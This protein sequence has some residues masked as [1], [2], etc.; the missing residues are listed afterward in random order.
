[1]SARS[2]STCWAPSTAG[3]AVSG[4]GGEPADQ[5]VAAVALEPDRPWTDSTPTARLEQAVPLARRLDR[6]RQQLVDLARDTDAAPR[7]IAELEARAESIEPPSR[8][9]TGRSTDRA[10]AATEPSISDRLTRLRAVADAADLPSRP[11]AEAAAADETQTR[12]RSEHLDARERHQDLRERYLDGIAVRWP[13]ELTD[14]RPCGVRLARP[15]ATG[16]SRRHRAGV[17]QP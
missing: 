13:P 12:R 1:M 11:R 6:R 4:S 2:R 9:S 15:S 5:L 14:D 7:S 3:V 10:S 16:L 17:G 8:R